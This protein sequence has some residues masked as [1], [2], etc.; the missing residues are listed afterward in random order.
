MQI[1]ALAYGADS[2][3]S[4]CFLRE[5]DREMV[6]EMNHDMLQWQ[7]NPRDPEMD[8]K[9]KLGVNLVRDLVRDS[10]RDLKRR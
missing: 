9:R 1:E 5:A 3:G 2:D 8:T 6:H 7:S 4:L 10:E